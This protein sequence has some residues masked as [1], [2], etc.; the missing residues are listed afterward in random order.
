MRLFTLAGAAVASPLLEPVEYAGGSVTSI[1]T[2]PGQVTRES[3]TLRGVGIGTPPS[4]NFQVSI[5]SLPAAKI[6]SYD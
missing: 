1:A 6:T 4:L 2:G 3:T 5:E